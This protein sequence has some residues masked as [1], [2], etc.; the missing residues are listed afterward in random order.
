MADKKISELVSAT[1]LNLTDFFP[2]VQAGTTLKIDLTT[3]LAK[4][5][6]QPIIA[7]AQEAPASGALSTSN[8][9]S[10]VTSAAGAV[11][12]TLAAGTH[13]VNKVIVAPA[14]GVDATAVVTVKSGVGF[15]TLRFNAAGQ[16]VHLENVGG[17]WY[18]LGVHGAVIA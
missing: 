17:S 2:I 6:G 7:L 13:G 8:K 9:Y 3:F 10:V 12:Y 5:P 1:V 18:I 16:A 15:T 14:M 4:L 11:N